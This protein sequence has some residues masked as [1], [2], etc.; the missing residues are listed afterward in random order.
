MCD[1]VVWVDAGRKGLLLAALLNTTCDCCCLFA[2]LFDMF[3]TGLICE[4]SADFLGTLIALPETAALLR[5]VR[6][7]LPRG[8]LSVLLDRLSVNGG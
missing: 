3:W 5:V 1:G 8:I 6:G 7:V 2:L 4:G